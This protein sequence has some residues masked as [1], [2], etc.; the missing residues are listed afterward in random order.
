MTFTAPKPG[1]WAFGEVLASS[2]MNDFNTDHPN[3][4][5]G[6]A[7]GTY[8]PS[9]AI[10]VGGSGLT[11]TG[12]LTATGAVAFS[13][14]S[15][16]SWPNEA[17]Y[18]TVSGSAVAI[19]GT[20]TLTQVHAGSGYTLSSNQ[21]EVPTAGKYLVGISIQSTVNNA[22]NPTE[23]AYDV[24]RGGSG[25]VKAQGQRFSATT[26]QEMQ[27]SA[28]GIIDITTPA[29]EKFDVSNQ[30]NG[31]ASLVYYSRLSLLRVA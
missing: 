31:Q 30:S 18:Y 29:S 25:V 7:G 23:F 13:G 22:A 12:T 2:E 9:S 1:G 21:V 15:S 8:A 5:D 14:A 26:T 24:E 17:A 27:V 10:T 20:L 6:A 11:T 19:G 3:A 4:V 16:F 28:T